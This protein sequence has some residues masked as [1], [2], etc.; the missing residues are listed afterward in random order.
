MRSKRTLQAAAISLV[1]VFF[2]LIRMHGSEASCLWFDEI[3]SVHAAAQPWSAILSFVSKDLIHPPLFY[4]LL[5]LWVNIGGDSL[6]WLR[7]LPVVFACLSVIPFLLMTKELKLEF[8]SRL[9]ALA[10]PCNVSMSNCSGTS[11]RRRSARLDRITWWS[12]PA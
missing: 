1:V 4:I 11:I 10:M 8:R 6:Q 5:K 2:V 7:L 12:G 3:F 9:I